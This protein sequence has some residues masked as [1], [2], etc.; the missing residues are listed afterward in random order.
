MRA[1]HYLID[2]YLMF[3]IPKEERSEKTIHAEL[4]VASARWNNCIE[5]MDVSR[6]YITVSGDDDTAQF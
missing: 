2:G 5:S 1:S 4:N 6:T 3:G